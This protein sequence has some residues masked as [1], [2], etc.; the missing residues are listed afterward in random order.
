MFGGLSG[1]RELG[2]GK[3]AGAVLLTAFIAL[4]VVQEPGSLGPA[5]TSHVQDILAQLKDRDPQA[6]QAAVM[7]LSLAGTKASGAVPALLEVLKD[8]VV[9]AEAAALAAT[10]AKR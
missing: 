1:E 5:S 2:G 10:L 4:S 3:S 6:R 7:M 8:P 9:A